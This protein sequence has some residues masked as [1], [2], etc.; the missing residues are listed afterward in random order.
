MVWYLLL[1]HTPALFPPPTLL[2]P[3]LEIF[4]NIASLKEVAL[5]WI[6]L[7][8]VQMHKTRVEV[9]FLWARQGSRKVPTQNTASAVCLFPYLVLTGVSHHFWIKHI[10]LEII[11]GRKTLCLKHCALLLKMCEQHRAGYLKLQFIGLAGTVVA[12]SRCIFHNSRLFSWNE[13]IRNL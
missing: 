5:W 9:K 4:Y 11:Q 7:C 6:S 12:A 10:L 1:L 2:H 3:N 13:A 8:V